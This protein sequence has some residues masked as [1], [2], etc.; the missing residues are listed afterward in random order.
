MFTVFVSQKRM[1]ILHR[2]FRKRCELGGYMTLP[3]GGVG[4]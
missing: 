2:I 4:S 1:S 3:S